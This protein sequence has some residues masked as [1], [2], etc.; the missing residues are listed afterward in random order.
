MGVAATVVGTAVSIYGSYEAG[1]DADAA[2]AAAERDRQDRL[3]L[4]KQRLEMSQEQ[5]DYNMYQQQ[6]WN[7]TYGAIE[8]N[9]ADY[10]GSLDPAKFE[11]QMNTD[12]GTAYNAAK[13]RLDAN[14][15]SRGL[16]GSGIEA[17]SLSQ[18]EV[19]RADAEAS[20]RLR[21]EEYVAG[22]QAG[23]AHQQAGRRAMLEQNVQSA[24]LGTQQSVSGVAN[25]YGES[26][27]QNMALA[28]QYG[29]SQAGYTAAAGSFLARGI[30]AYKGGDMVHDY[31]NPPKDIKPSDRTQ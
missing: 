9:V 8:K 12:I 20:T 10:Y 23:F 25:V 24:M 2:Q 17:E 21:A 7:S 19:G 31:F 16:Q 28:Q 13:E 3:K 6:L 26:Y 5:L 29:K 14:L 1:K 15:A 27:G 22:Q 4:E 30:D 11:A 18:L